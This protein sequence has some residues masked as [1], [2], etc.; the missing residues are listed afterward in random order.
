MSGLVV[1]LRER[2]TAPSRN[3]DV[4]I[5]TRA[6]NFCCIHP[7]IGD[8]NID[9]K[10]A[11]AAAPTINVRLHPRSSLIGNTKTAIVKVAAALRTNIVDPAASATAQP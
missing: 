6:P 7:A 9:I 8:T 2:I 5:R 1:H 3:T 10:P 11:A 4:L